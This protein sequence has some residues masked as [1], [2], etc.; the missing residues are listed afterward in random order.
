MRKT[1][2]S[3]LLEKFFIHHNGEYSLEYYETKK[4]FPFK[5][6]LYKSTK[7][8]F[9]AIRWFKINGR[10]KY[11]G[12]SFYENGKICSRGIFHS[13]QCLYKGTNYREDGTKRF[14]GI[15]NDKHAEYK[16]NG[17]TYYGPSYPVYGTYYNEAGKKAYKGK[18]KTVHL[19][20]VRYP[21]VVFP[22]DYGAI[23]W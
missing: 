7:I 5:I 21:S 13:A 12:I 6:E 23:R 10:S 8:E 14:K 9:F 11:L 1:F 3:K 15:C 16:K 19:G 20:G 4:Y 17:T 2:K 18:F 22:E